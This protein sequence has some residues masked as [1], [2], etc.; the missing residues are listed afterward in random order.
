MMA[1]GVFAGVH[2]LDYAYGRTDL[3]GK[4]F[5][6]ELERIGWKGSEEVGARRMHAYFELHI[7]QGPIL[8]PRAATSASSP[9]A[10]ACG[11]SN[12]P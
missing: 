1:S 10:R 9:T 4:R 8:R 3:D 7:E 5:G 2:T 12:S 11:G 6:E